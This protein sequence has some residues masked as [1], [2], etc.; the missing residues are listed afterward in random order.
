MCLHSQHDAR[1]RTDVSSSKEMDSGPPLASGT[2]IGLAV[3]Q[4]MLEPSAGAEDPL[5][6][7]ITYERIEGWVRLMS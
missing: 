3:R 7:L 5:R 1:E 6:H 4:E 2:E